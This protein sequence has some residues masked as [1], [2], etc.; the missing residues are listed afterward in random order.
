MFSYYF[1][2]KMLFACAIITSTAGA[3][4]FCVSVEL[5]KRDFEPINV[6]VFFGLFSNT[7]WSC[8]IVWSFTWNWAYYKAVVWVRH[9][10]I[11]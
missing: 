10:H 9:K 5:Q 2:L 7:M 11:A 8:T 6:L 1:F 4:K 3:N